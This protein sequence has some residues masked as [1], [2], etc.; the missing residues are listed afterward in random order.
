MRNSIQSIIISSLI[1]LGILVLPVAGEAAR[2]KY[3][4]KI[5]SLAPDGSVWTNHFR[6][7][8]K[9]VT[10]KSNG[11]IAFKIYPGGVMGDDRAMYRKMKIGQL[12]GG[13]FT[14][15]G[16]SDIVPDFRVLGIP[17]LLNSYEEVDR[18]QE[19]L[20]PSFQK[21]FKEKGL[22]L[23]AMTEVGFVY[24]MSAN[25]IEDLDQMRS[26][27]CWAP[28]NDPVGLAFF[29][30][31]GITPIQLTI[32]D[33]LPSLQ[34]GMI[35]TIFN[36]FY[37]SL[38]LQWFTKTKYITNTPFLYAYGGVIF[39]KRMMDKMPPHYQEMVKQMAAKHFG[40]LLDDTRKSNAEALQ[41][42]KDHGIQVIEATDQAVKELYGHKEQTVK[43]TIGKSYS[44]EI[45]DIVVNCLS[46]IRGFAKA[47]NDNK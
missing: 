41:A 9:E 43:Q 6:N 1:I 10:E 21:V 29:K 19:K 28:A 13:G 44:K 12:H 26:G 14:M 37:G 23:L 11:E 18:L 31:M 38:V 20:F 42:M 47:E 40:K 3:T 4:L 2:A 39:S 8:A 32:P 22:E 15:T 34:T 46:E 30:D 17:M 33:V 35:D 27:K 16:I 5:A 24:T 36:S 45:Y 7:F 25:P